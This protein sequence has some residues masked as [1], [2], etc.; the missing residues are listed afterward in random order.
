MSLTFS[1]AVLELIRQRPA[2]AGELLTNVLQVNLPEFDG[3]RLDSP[4]FT[5]AMPAEYRVDAAVT[6]TVRDSP[7]VR[8][9]GCTDLDQ[10]ET[11]VR[12][13]ATATSANDLFE[14]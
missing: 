7:G 8:N 3:V 11:W 12:R 10:L 4:D 13:A 1:E 9:A 14:S 6:F 2:F 5:N